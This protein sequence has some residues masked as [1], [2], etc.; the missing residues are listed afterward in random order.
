MREKL[1]L[2]FSFLAVCLLFGLC[3]SNA[4]A[5][6]RTDIAKTAYVDRAHKGLVLNF[7]GFSEKGEYTFEIATG[8]S[9]IAEGPAAPSKI[10][11]LGDKYKDNTPYLLVITSKEQ[12]TLSILYYTGNTLNQAR[13]SQSGQNIKYVWKDQKKSP[14]TGYLAQVCK[15]GTVRPVQE[16]NIT[17]KKS[18]VTL[19]GAPL[20]NGEYETKFIAYKNMDGNI[21][22]G[23][24]F[25][26]AITYVKIPAKISKIKAEPDTK[27][28][29][30][31]W[32]PSP[33]ANSYRIYQSTTSSGKYKLALDNVTTTTATITGLKAGSRYYFKIEPVAAFGTKT[34]NGP[35][36]AAKGATVP[37]VAGK[38]QNVKPHL[39]DNNTMYLTWS[40]TKHAYGYQVF[41]K[42]STDPTFVKLA[43]TTK[44]KL[45]LNNINENAIYEF[46]VYAVTKKGLKKYR[47]D[48][49]SAVLRF[50]PVADINRI[51]AGEVRTI[52]Y[53]GRSREIYTSKK[54]SPRVKTAYVNY[55]GNRFKSPTPYLIWVSHYTQQAT[56]FQGSAGKWN[57]IRS[58]NVATGRAVSRSPRGIFK[59]GRKERGWFYVNTKVL[60]VTHYKG[61]NAFHTRPLY[62]GGG[63]AT[64][65]LGRPAS[66]GCIRC[67]NK[68]AR[69]IY[70]SMPAGTTVISY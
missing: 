44:T 15:K 25:S 47:S 40:K 52:K 17:N 6:E 69:F 24:G 28:M 1:H 38:V 3:S 59:I 48:V 45:Y 46:I 30:L 39:D 22:Y 61:E 43:G 42:K 55:Y 8:G 51:L 66:H 57:M 26:Q 14:Y 53:V 21:Y 34:V 50:N 60:Y 33:G 63:V 68:D 54:Y 19:S 2:M 31:L 49:H 58:F 32:N 70:K 16:M 36:S 20:Q 13:G 56:I 11:P 41:Y 18:P 67:E 7:E 5:A 37:V 65:T 4:L 29:N 9:V 35:K 62:N 10:Y 23:E 12:D 64:P 27:S